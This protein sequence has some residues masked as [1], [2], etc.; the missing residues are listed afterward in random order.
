M[1]PALTHVPSPHLHQ[2]QLTHV[3]PAPI[4]LTRAAAQHEAYCQ[5]LR[6]GGA[7]VRV[8]D[9]NRDEP[10][11]VFIED[12]AV[13]LDEV[14]VLA[15]MGTPARR[16]EA[17]GVGAVLREYRRA[18]RRIEPPATLE[19]GDVL[20]VGRRLL[21][22]LSCRTNAAGLAAFAEIVRPFGYTVEA[23]PLRGCLH[24][25][26]ACTALDEQ[27]LIVNPAWLDVNDLPPGSRHVAV[28][29]DEPWAA[30]VLP[31][32]GSILLAAGQPGTAELIHRLGFDP[33]PVNISEF[34][35][36]EGGVTCLSILL[37]TD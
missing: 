12:T 24:L 37:G 2:C 9:V 20:R 30:N 6:E 1:M 5:A 4:D 34:A 15:S 29:D 36:A 27:T 35:K 25:K 22:G 11:G 8:L 17:A 19:G 23:V 32:G 7:A 13:V 33:R 21:V 28:P 16:A 10:D 14:A 3:A 31:I 18:L 26:T